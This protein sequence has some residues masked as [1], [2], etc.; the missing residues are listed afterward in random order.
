M[1]V[2]ECKRKFAVTQR[3]VTTADRRRNRSLQHIEWS[4]HAKLLRVDSFVDGWSV[5]TQQVN[6]GGFELLWIVFV[7]L[8][9][10]DFESLSRNALDK[11]CARPS[12]KG[13]ERCLKDLAV[14][15]RDGVDNAKGIRKI[16]PPVKGAGEQAL[17]MRIG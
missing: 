2:P 8:V 17:W 15:G 13:G 4:R 11:D 5:L 6:Y 14:A 1:H 9:H 10:D 3:G 12:L 16:E 7:A